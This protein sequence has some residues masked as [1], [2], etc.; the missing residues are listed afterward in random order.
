MEGRPEV[1]QLS[2]FMSLKG[3]PR[4]LRA[5]R[6][7]EDLRDRLRRYSRG[8]TSCGGRGTPRALRGPR[9][10]CTGRSPVQGRR[11][12]LKGPGVASCPIQ[13]GRGALLCTGPT[14]RSP[15]ARQGL[16]SWMALG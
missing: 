14:G 4:A 9:L 12:P 5:M 3:Y 7:Q 8:G 16:P 13:R 2:D 1:G 6:P 10:P 11:D 15:Q